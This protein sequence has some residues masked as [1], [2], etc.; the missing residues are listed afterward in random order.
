MLQF[1]KH[2]I[3][4]GQFHAFD[5]V[6]Y[7]AALCFDKS[8]YD[9]RLLDD[10]LASINR[11]RSSI[12]CLIASRSSSVNDVVESSGGCCDVSAA[13]INAPVRTTFAMASLR[14]S[15]IEDK[16]DFQE[17]TVPTDHNNRNKQLYNALEGGRLILQDHLDVLDFGCQSI[18]R[19]HDLV[20]QPSVSTAG[21]S[22]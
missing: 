10:R 20:S 8:R 19:I 4:G 17:E 12:L 2:G 16:G 5:V 14:G 22:T 7:S 9:W 15:C 6:L 18:P 21:T 11:R 13:T 3:F 1:H